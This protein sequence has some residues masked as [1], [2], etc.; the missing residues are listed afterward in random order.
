MRIAQASHDE[1]G[2]YRG[3]TAGNQSGDELNIK[4]WYN[5]PWNVVFRPKS[6]VFGDNMATVAEMLVAN[7]NVGYDQGERT[8][9]Y[10][11][12]ARIGWNPSLINTLPPCECDCSSLIA[13]VLRFLG[14]AIPKT[15]TTMTMS[16][17]LTTTGLFDR[18]TESQY[19]QTGDRLRRGDILLNTAHHVAIAV[20]NGQAPINPY[21][22][23]VTASDY[24]NVRTGPGTN[25]PIVKVNGSPFAL[26]PSMVVAICEEVNGWGRLS[27]ISGWVY[28]KYI[29]K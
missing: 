11:S 15:V 27:N 28:L 13:V 1:M 17:A 19:L 18:L 10:D 21:A 22:G 25:Y 5:R 8:T 3:G 20:D 26:P 23:T 16:A 29:H 9:L 14:V 7:R 12:C 24:L 4:S 2:Q 6:A